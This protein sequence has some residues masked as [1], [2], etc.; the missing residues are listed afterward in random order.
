MNAKQKMPTTMRC[1]PMRTCELR[2]IARKEYHMSVDP[3]WLSRSLGLPPRKASLVEAVARWFIGCYQSAYVRGA[4]AIAA[5]AASDG[6]AKWGAL[7]KAHRAIYTPGNEYALWGV[8][9]FAKGLTP[10]EECAKLPAIV[11]RIRYH[12]REEDPVWDEEIR[13]FMEQVDNDDVGDFRFDPVPR[14]LTGGVECVMV[15]CL[16]R[17]RDMP[18]GVLNRRLLPVLI[19][20]HPPC[21]IL[22]PSERWPGFFVAQWRAATITFGPPPLPPPLSGSAVE[23]AP[24]DELPLFAIEATGLPPERLRVLESAVHDGCR[25]QG[26]KCYFLN[27]GSLRSEGAPSPGS[28]DMHYLGPLTEEPAAR[29]MLERLFQENLTVEQRAAVQMASMSLD[30]FFVRFGRQIDKIREE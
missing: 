2:R 28:G 16:F 23:E 4:N 18:G 29:Q 24:E 21:A 3:H 11:E 5:L 8:I 9:V 12:R 17:R 25:R 1:A 19:T 27:V 20:D 6:E 22:V 14:S 10:E 7:L 15:E 13:A 30:A 26:L